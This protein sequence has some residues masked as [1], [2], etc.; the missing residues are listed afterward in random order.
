MTMCDW[1]SFR[2]SI[3]KPERFGGMPTRGRADSEFGRIKN[4]LTMS[5]GRLRI[6][7]EEVDDDDLPSLH[8][9]SGTSSEEELRIHLPRHQIGRPPTAAAGNSAAPKLPGRPQQAA[10]T[11]VPS[12]SQAKPVAMT[13]APIVP[14]ALPAVPR[15]RNREDSSDSD[16]GPPPLAS[17]SESG[18][19]MPDLA[20]TSGRYAEQ[21]R[22]MGRMGHMPA[23][24]NSH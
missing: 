2:T 21:E 18:T 7:V 8:S 24:R 6:E 13:S 5:E 1:R 19:S 14:N 15:G 12:Q 4:V 10:K 20:D 17:D 11:S 3:Q 23:W 22:N 9:D 16:D